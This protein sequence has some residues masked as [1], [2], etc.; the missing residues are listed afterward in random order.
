MLRLGQYRRVLGADA[1]N[2]ARDPTLVFVL[3]FS[4]VPSMALF[5]GEAALDRWSLAT[6]SYAFGPPALVVALAL[7]AFL[8][9]LIGGF[10]LL[11]DRDD[12][13]LRALET[14]PVGK[15][16]FMQYRI[17]MVALMAALLTLLTLALNRPAWG[18]AT[19]FGFALLVALE[20]VFATFI[21][22]ALARNKVEGLAIAKLVNMLI[23][24]GL[25]ALV[26]GAWRFAFFAVPTFWLGEFAGLPSGGGIGFLAG[27]GPALAVHLALVW[28]MYRFAT[29][30]LG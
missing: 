18:V 28:L 25:L 12:G 29:R 6:F 27:I 14:T 5:F 17:V 21:L 9:G 4:V 11:D 13:V 3:V 20:G 23:L 15:G 26:P 1:R 10:L 2:I 7:P 8:A 22:P 16:G 30:R 19:A 24:G